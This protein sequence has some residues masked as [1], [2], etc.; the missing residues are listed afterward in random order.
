MKSDT[1]GQPTIAD[2]G[3]IGDGHTA[4]LVSRMGSIDWA[5]LPRLDSPSVFG[6][7]LDADAGHC[8]IGTPTPTEVTRRYLPGTLILETTLETKTGV[9]KLTDCITMKAGGATDPHR[10][11]L[12]IVE[13]MTG[14]VPI[15]IELSPRFDFGAIRP[16]TRTIS[17]E[18]WA[19]LGGAVGLLIESNFALQADRHDLSAEF[20]IEAGD[21]RH[22]SISF[23][24]PEVLDGS[25]PDPIAMESVDERLRETV[26]W[27]HRWHT[28]RTDRE[29]DGVVRSAIVLKA[30]TNPPTGA[31]AAAAT[32]SLPEAMGG[33]RNWDYRFSWIRD[34]WLTLRALRQLGFHAE[35]D[36][37]ARFVARSAAG[38]GEELQVMYGLGGE[39][40]LTERSLDFLQGFG[41]SRPVRVGNDAY[42]QQQLDIFGELLDVIWMSPDAAHVID[43]D[44]WRFL[45]EVAERAA[46]EWSEPDRG[47][48]EVRG[49]PRHFTFSKAMCWVALDRGVR[50]AV[51]HGRSAPV[52][53]WQRTREEIRRAVLDDSYSPE[54]GAFT[55]AIGEKDLDS[56]VLLLPATGIV[57]YR[58]RRMRSTVD[59]LIETLDRDGLLRRYTSADGLDGEEGS[60]L[61]CTFWLA[62]V[63][64]N[65]DRHRLALDYFERAQSTG[66]DLGLM[67]EEY[68]MKNKASLGNFPQAMTHLGHI[69]AAL[70]I[71]GMN[72]RLGRLRSDHQ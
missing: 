41:N 42:K 52:E 68:D 8:L 32:T 6:R 38:S 18:I 45:V 31:I 30:L 3:L 9:A 63:L 21:R 51:R 20:E 66:N 58:D 29:P 27:W 2:Y 39:R 40:D 16:W 62:E 5:C 70:A 43:D 34:S 26:D 1:R 49:G 50:L 12:R 59:A 47:I 22:L 25:K 55:Q 35:A 28:S 24:N 48:W 64:A 19:C 11:I 72:M 71:E 36:G 53:R 54:S 10:Q 17:N 37:F 13:G 60:F 44:M 4:A 65:Q 15:V 56:A 57:D 61:A 67:S 7:L 23:R 14:T 46:L 69:G 33:S